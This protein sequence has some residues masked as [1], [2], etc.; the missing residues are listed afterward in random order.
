MILTT[1]EVDAYRSLYQ[2]KLALPQLAIFI[3]RNDAGK[4]NILRAVRLLLDDKATASVNR[5]D[6]SKLWLFKSCRGRP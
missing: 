4:S 6:R 5:Y 2:F 3:G 1:L